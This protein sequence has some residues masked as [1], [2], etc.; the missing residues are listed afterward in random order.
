MSTIRARGQSNA[1]GFAI[2]AVLW[3][4]GA[5]AALAAIYAA[6]IINTTQAFAANDDRIRATAAISAS[7]ALTA[8]QLSVPKGEPAPHHGRF[9]FRLDRAQVA[10]A[11]AS[12]GARI[13]LNAA[14]QPL[15]AGL[16]AAL[17]ASAQQAKDYAE[18]V[19]AWRTPPQPNTTDN[20]V[21]LYRA[22]GLAYDPRQAPF[23]S[24]AELWLVRG[25]PPQ[26]V[27]HA[28]SFV[29]VFN[30]SAGVDL[31][32]AA[33]MVIAALPGMTPDRLNAILRQ[34]QADP[35][36]DK[37]L[38][39]LLGPLQANVATAK[40]AA[41]RVAVRV[42][43]DDGRRVKAEAVIAPASDA[44]APYRVLAWRDDLDGSIQSEQTDMA[45]R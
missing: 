36:D 38:L 16:F 18:R 15:L 4:V 27:A 3:I 10:V 43:F 19:V 21:S 12:E 11:F 22:A 41:T 17:G 7:L 20:E 32:D 35:Q 44:N 6:Y 28:M 29:T 40:N 42:R 34:R 23:A 25:L 8:N 14:P 5:L 39:A 9:A 1:E 26:L 2:V 31:R 13:D 24:T 37:A 33:P 30:G 45:L